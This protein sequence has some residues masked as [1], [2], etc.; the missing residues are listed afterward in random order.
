SITLRRHGRA[1]GHHPDEIAVNERGIEL[2]VGEGAFGNAATGSDVFH[3]ENDA[4][5]LIEPDLALAVRCPRGN[6]AHAL[7][8]APRD[9]VLAEVIQRGV[10]ALDGVLELCDELPGRLAARFALLDNTQG[11][12]V[13]PR[14]AP[15]VE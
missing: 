12:E 11:V 7:G 9:R 14:G 1:R 13:V 4:G 10:A 15:V 3:A 6:D 2:D 5:L 8:L